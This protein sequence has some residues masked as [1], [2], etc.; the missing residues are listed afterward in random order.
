VTDRLQLELLDG[1]TQ[2]RPGEVIEGTASWEL[3]EPPQQL[4]VHL[5]WHTEGR[6]TKDVSIVETIAYQNPQRYDNRPFRFKVPDGPYSYD[7]H[8]IAIEWGIELL[9]EGTREVVQV[10]LVIS[11][12]GEAFRD[13]SG[14]DPL[15]GG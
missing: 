9:G 7:G 6:G 13:L 4:E 15:D 2:Y 8:L 5:F 10:P 12:T 3:A 11:P 1:R 14:A